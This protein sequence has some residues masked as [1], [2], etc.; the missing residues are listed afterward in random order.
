MRE[1]GIVREILKIVRP[2]NGK[3]KIERKRLRLIKNNIEEKKRKKCE[4]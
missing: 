2:Y 1:G 3:N 4:T